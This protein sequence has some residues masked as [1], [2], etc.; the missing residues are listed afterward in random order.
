MQ[1]TDHGVAR[2]HVM[3]DLETLGTAPGSAIL[4]IGA[5][6]F[7]S[8]GDCKAEFDKKILPESCFL[9]GLTSD[10]STKDWWDRQSEELKREVFSGTEHI[11]DVLTEFYF[12]LDSLGG[13]VYLWGNGA[14]FDPVLLEAA[15]EKLNMKLPW[16]FRNVRCYR[17]VTALFP[18]PPEVLPPINTN[19]HNALA[20]AMYQAEVLLK[21]HDY[22][23]EVSDGLLGIL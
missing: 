12:W 6:A 9:S 22:I 10:D 4:Q 3:L 20:D 14:A 23:S 1:Y 21:T 13:S 5:V 11:H 19:S 18:L 8:F 16:K 17:T 7:N 15:Y 2:N